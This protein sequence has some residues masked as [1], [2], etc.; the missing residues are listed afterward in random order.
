MLDEI[1]RYKIAET[2]QRKQAFGVDRMLSRIEGARRPRDFA[3]R[4]VG[5]GVSIIAE[6]K[7]RS[8]SKGVLRA[9]YD[10]LQLA[11]AYQA[12]GASALSVIADS[13][14]FGNAPHIVGQLANHPSLTLPVM[15][16]DFIVDEYQ[17]FEARALG[18][19]AV[20]MIVRCLPANSLERLHRLATEL[21]LQVLVETFD[22]ADIDQALA[23]DASIIGINNRDLET[24]QV[25]FDRTAQLFERL[26]ASVVAVAESG[27]AGREDMC[28]VEAI[29]FSAALIGERLL[30]APDPELEVRHL[31]G[32]GA[33][34]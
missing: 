16:K 9:D 3:A 27:I 13:R 34:A 28:T 20:L 11:L 10:P 12:G 15:Y 7:Y 26:P 24:F 31:L 17:I 30:S 2:A 22:E 32:R 4:L 23:A 8:P 25:N 29:G 19:D 1:V 5:Q 33:P 21:G 6:S 14:F 18:A